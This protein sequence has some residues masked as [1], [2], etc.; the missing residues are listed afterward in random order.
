[1]VQ[2]VLQISTSVHVAAFSQSKQIPL[3]FSLHTTNKVDT[4]ALII[5]K[6]GSGQGNIY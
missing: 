6:E 2:L 4:A 1:M 5:L 3:A